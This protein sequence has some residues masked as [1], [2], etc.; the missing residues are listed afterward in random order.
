MASITQLG[1][2]AQM[3]EMV[4]RSPPRGMSTKCQPPSGD[5][6]SVSDSI[7]PGGTRGVRIEPSR[8]THA[9]GGLR[10]TGVDCKEFIHQGLGGGRE[11]LLGYET[12]CFMAPA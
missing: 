6:I 9:D 1:V 5:T 2:W 7:S 12:D 3:A 8:A 4:D 11:M 10:T